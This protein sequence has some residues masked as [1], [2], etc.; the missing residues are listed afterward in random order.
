MNGPLHAISFDVEEY[1]QVAN[2][3]GVFTRKDW[4]RVD[5]RIGR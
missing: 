5:S 2:M 3:R 4:D 1:F